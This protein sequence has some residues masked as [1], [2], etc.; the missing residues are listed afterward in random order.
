MTRVRAF[1][2][3][4]YLSLEDCRISP[5][6][7]GF[8]F[9]DGIYE[10]LPVYQGSPFYLSQHLSRLEHSLQEIRINNPHSRDEWNTIVATLIQQSDSEDLAIY[11]Q[12]TRGVAPR[13]HVF[14]KDASATVFAMA[15]PLTKVPQEQLQN[16]VALITANDIRWQRCDIKVIGL[17]ANVLAKQDALQASATEAIMIRDG[18]ALEGAASNLFIVRAGKVFTHPK[19][20]LILP[21]ITRDIILELLADLGV[22]Y[23]EQPIPKEWLYSSEEIWVTSSARE[24][25]AATKI[26]GQTVG[27]GMPGEVWKRVY[28]L[29]QQR[30][31]QPALN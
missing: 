20:N 7:R 4:T 12:V 9:G 31:I 14:P 6:D 3:G 29:Y 28:A 13:D 24:I 10:L 11:I 30:K 19:D 21:G 23:V 18:I 16:G 26:D 25:L 2:N 15:N 8:L 17:Q 1:L 5:L 27:N 22:A